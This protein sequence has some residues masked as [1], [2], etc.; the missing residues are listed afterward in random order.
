MDA[1]TFHYVH[2]NDDDSKGI[3]DLWSLPWAYEE[4]NR[5]AI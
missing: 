3:K 1:L 2:V 5:R 4:I